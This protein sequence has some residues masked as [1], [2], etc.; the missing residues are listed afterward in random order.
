MKD[1]IIFVMVMMVLGSGYMFGTKLAPDT[2]LSKIP[3]LDNN[4]LNYLNGH[5]SGGGI[6]SGIEDGYNALNSVFN[7]FE[8]LGNLCNEYIYE[9]AYTNA[10]TSADQ[11]SDQ[12]GLISSEEA[13][14]IAQ[15]YIEEPGAVAGEPVPGT[16][17]GKPIYTVPVLLNGKN[18]GEIYIDAKTGENL[19]GA[20]G[21]D[22]NKTKKHLNNDSKHINESN[23]ENCL[24]D[25]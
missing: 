17:E 9:P 3:A 4:G 5:E 19:G 18:V 21:V 2:G 1:I 6:Y 25:N 7:N 10:Q 8:G 13:K 11:L 14:K 23:K 20:G 16:S 12:S 24:N 15:R 22:D